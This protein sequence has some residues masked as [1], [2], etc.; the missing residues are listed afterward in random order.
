[1]GEVA[2]P[3]ANTAGPSHSTY[4]HVLSKL[5]IVVSK[6]L[7]GFSDASE[8][9]YA[10]ATYLRAIDWIGSTHIALVMGKTRVAPIKRLTIPRLELSDTLVT[11]KLLHQCRKILDVPLS[12]T[13]V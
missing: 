7:H 2:K 1:M 10:G 9:T 5:S 4:L 11:A 3:A 13:F 8:S 6:Q 12:A